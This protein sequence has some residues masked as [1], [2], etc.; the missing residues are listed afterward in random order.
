MYL[1]R[2]ELPF[3]SLDKVEKFIKKIK[4]K[5]LQVLKKKRKKIC[6]S[7]S[8]VN[9]ILKSKSQRHIVDF[10]QFNSTASYNTSLSVSLLVLQTHRIL[11]QKT[12]SI[13]LFSSHISVH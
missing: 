1:M 11:R 10:V 13:F 12:Q 6:D 7:I 9:V 5:T 4:E 3:I 8:I 2:I